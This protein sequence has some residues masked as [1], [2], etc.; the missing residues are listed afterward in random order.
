MPKAT[1]TNEMYRR[2]ADL[3]IIP[4]IGSIQ[5]VKLKRADIQGFYDKIIEVG[6][7]DNV[8][9]RVKPKDGEIKE[10][11][12]VGKETLLYYHR[13][14]CRLLNHAMYEDEILDKN[15]ALK[16]VL[17]EPIKIVD[18]DPDESIVKVFTKD[19]IIKLEDAADKDPKAIPYTNLIKAA[20]RTGK[21]REELLALTWDCV[22]FKQKTITI[23]KAV[24]CTTSKGYEIKPTKNKK[25]R[26]IEVTD[27]VLNAFRAEARRQA[28][29]KLRLKNNYLK[30]KLIFCREDGFYSHPDSISSWFPDFCDSIK[31]SRLSFHCLRHTHASHLLASGEDISYVSKRLGHSSI[32]IT[33]GK[34]FHFIPLEKREALKELEKRFKK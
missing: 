13:F 34:Y 20:L 31:I 28:P 7:F 21:R 22:N 16:I 29:F 4:W 12:E 5:L 24:I 18:F 26:L 14:L 23:K 3:R 11:K 8:R 32:D 6:H 15:V 33:Y 9:P 27:E 17:P 10:R 19:E 30:N 25:R 1:K 2:C